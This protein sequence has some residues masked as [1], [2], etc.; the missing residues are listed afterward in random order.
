MDGDALDHAARLLARARR[1]LFLTGAGMSAESGIP[2]FRDEGGYWRRF[3]P[4]ARLGLAAQDL[5]SPWAFRHHLAHAWAFYEWRRRNA[6]ENAPH[7]GY[8]VITRWL[9]ERFPEGFVHTTNT[10]GYHLRAGIAP[11]RLREVHGSMWRLQCLRPCS[12]RFWEE[13]RVPLCDLDEV[14]ME[15]SELPHCDRC[16]GVA[17][18]HILMFGDGDYVGHPDQDAAWEAFVSGGVDLALLIGASGAVPTN[19]RIAATLQRRGC[20]VVT[21]NPDPTA[22]G[23]LRPDVA[24]HLPAGEALIALDDRL[25]GIAGGSRLLP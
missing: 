20:K 8:A 7:A 12:R 4:F 16:G 18:P 24:L 25:G 14:T 17:R 9:A 1:P 5:A 3:P 15:A 10:D 6:A 13:A 23:Y 11:D 2:T 19:D 21:L 22:G